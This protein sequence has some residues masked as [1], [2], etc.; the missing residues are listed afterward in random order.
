MKFFTY[1]SIELCFNPPIYCDL[2]CMYNSNCI[3]LLRMV[4]KIAILLNY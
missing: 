2:S 4:S 3:Y 1:K